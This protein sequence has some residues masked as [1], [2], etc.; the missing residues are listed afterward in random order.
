MAI[1]V[2]CKNCG[3]KIVAKDELLGQTRRCPKC[4]SPVLI[5]PE[6]DANV[7]YKNTS[8]KSAYDVTNQ[9]LSPGPSSLA[10]DQEEIITA[11]LAD[12]LPIVY[13]NLERLPT[14]EPPAKLIPD[15]R[16]FIFS[17]EQLIAHWEVGKG[18]QFNTGNGYVNARQNRELLPNSGTFKFVE[19]IIEQQ[20]TGR[21][22]SGL[23]TFSISGR[24]AIQAIACEPEDILAKIDGKAVLTKQQRQ[25]LLVF[26]RQ[27]Y[28]PE[29]LQNTNAVYEYLICE[30]TR[31]SD[32]FVS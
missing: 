5:K 19:M 28:M 16:Y 2:R 32:V 1:R 8:A 22:M 3:S 13:D 18:W 4:Q 25:Q 12:D 24:W 27:H 11:E 6:D 7:E 29:F 10:P 20:E 15:Y 23:R 21:Q 17:H 14:H 30:F 9:S 31:E 26:I